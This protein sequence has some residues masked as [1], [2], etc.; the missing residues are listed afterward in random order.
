MTRALGVGIIGASATRGWAKIS[1]VPAIQGLAGLEV[2]AVASG[3]QSKAEEAARAFGAK[4]GYADAEDLIKDPAV[5]IVTIAVKVPDHR[6]LVLAA[7]EASKHIYCEWPLGRSLAEAEELAAAAKATKVHVLTG[8]QT[9]LN[10]VML[11]ARDLVSTGTIGRPLAARI[12]SST[13][14]FGPKVET[15]MSFAEDPANG[16]TLVTIQGAHTLDFRIAVLGPLTDLS[17]LATTQ[18]RQ[19]TVGDSATQKTRLTHDH[20]LVQARVGAAIPL[21]VEVAGGRPIDSVAFRMEID[22]EMGTLHID[23]GAPRGFQSGK[24]IVSWCGELQ[25]VDEGEGAAMPAEA[26]N[27]ALMYAAL[28]NDFLSGTATVPD[29]EHAVRLTKL[30]SDLTASSRTGCRKLSADWPT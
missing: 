22:G 15:A 29:F 4:T 17:A 20:L 30:L 24:L 19:T 14:A 9:R 23:G 18:F 8:L 28:R 2:V 16:A 1:H 25:H 27:V 7:L 10:P 26:A 11:R 5:D 6:E 13:I 3:T 12:F 21:S